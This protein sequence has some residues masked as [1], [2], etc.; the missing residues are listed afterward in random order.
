MRPVRAKTLLLTIGVLGLAIVAMPAILSLN[1]RSTL[2]L[3]P[4]SYALIGLTTTLVLL[5]TILWVKSDANSRTGY[6][7]T[8]NMRRDQPRQFLVRS[9]LL[10]VAAS[11]VTAAVTWYFLRVAVPLVPGS[12][13]TVNGTIDAMQKQYGRGRTCNIRASLTLQGVRYRSVAICYEWGRFSPHRISDDTLSPGD[14][15]S[16]IVVE[17]RL[18]T[19]VTS[20]SRLRQE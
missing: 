12:P 8:A 9:L 19:A 14:R 4:I 15:I 16:A 11:G 10:V 6:S 3:S 7:F 2:W 5:G 13:V 1:F 20:L 17:N 18:G